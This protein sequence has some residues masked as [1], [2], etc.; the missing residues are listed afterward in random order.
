MVYLQQIHKQPKKQPLSCPDS[1]DFAHT[2]THMYEV[3]INLGC[4]REVLSELA[5]TTVDRSAPAAEQIAVWCQLLSQPTKS[6]GSPAVHI[7]N[8]SNSRL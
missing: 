5:V 1:P 8:N 6:S 7:Q 4:E 3:Q 2:H